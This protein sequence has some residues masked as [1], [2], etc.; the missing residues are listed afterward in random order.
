MAIAPGVYVRNRRFELFTHPGAKR[1]RARAALL[2]GVVRQLGLATDVTVTA[3]HGDASA[4]V[5]RYRI[6][7]MRMS[8]VVELSIAEL[9]AL[10][11][12]G[13]RA[14]VTCLPPADEDRVRVDVVL[15]H[16][17]D[18]SDPSGPSGPSDT[19]VRSVDRAP[20]DR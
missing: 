18:P 16:L 4:F 5:L 14:G 7:S 9:S 1:A 8:R 19:S 15:A 12:M 10:K 6:V 3:R 2:R 11:V 13:A 17:L 20:S